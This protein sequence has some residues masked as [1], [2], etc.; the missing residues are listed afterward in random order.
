MTLTED[1]PSRP[2]A[3]YRSSLIPESLVWMPPR[4]AQRWLTP[5]REP[6]C[7]DRPVNAVSL[8]NRR[9]EVDLSERA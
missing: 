6:V 3:R 2:S 5:E 7:A 4:P 8:P 1:V 9:G